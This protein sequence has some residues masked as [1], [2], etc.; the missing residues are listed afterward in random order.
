MLTRNMFEYLNTDPHVH[1]HLRQEVTNLTQH[2][3]KHWE[4]T[5]KDRD[6]AGKNTRK[7]SAHFVFLGSGGMAIP[8]L[9]K[10]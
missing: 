1:I 10:S 6:G 5:I 8:L 4:V 7:M 2:K 9:A 3:D